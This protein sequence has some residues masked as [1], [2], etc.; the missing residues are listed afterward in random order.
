M[1]R[2]KKVPIPRGQSYYPLDYNFVYHR[3]DGKVQ[4][5]YCG[6]FENYDTIT[7]DHVYPKSKGGSI[8]VPCC[9][10]CNEAKKDA[11]PIDWAIFISSTIDV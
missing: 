3:Y 2:K 4:C 11:L 5:S 8:T 7:R 9:Y 6:I 10:S 1:G